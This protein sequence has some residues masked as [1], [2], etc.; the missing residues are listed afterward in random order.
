M[1]RSVDTSEDSESK[2][3]SKRHPARATRL[4]TPL[5]FPGWRSIGARLTI[6]TLTSALVAVFVA[7]VALIAYDHVS[8]RD[9]VDHDLALLAAIISDGTAEVLV[10]DDRIAASE[11]LNA[12]S[13]QPGIKL[14]CVFNA[15]GETF[16]EYFRNDVE[17]ANCPVSASLIAQAGSSLDVTLSRPIFLFDEQIGTILILSDSDEFYSR[18]FNFAAVV[19]LVLLLAMLVVAMVSRRM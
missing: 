10:L 17:D 13:A 18:L 5:A 15:A 1:G 12:L 4:D 2:S 8:F 19:A 3:K 16:A 11:T 7:F 14:A 6:V 9:H